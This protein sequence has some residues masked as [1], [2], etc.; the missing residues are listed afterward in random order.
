MSN[1]SYN[2][3]LH[4]DTGKLHYRQLNLYLCYIKPLMNVYLTEFLDPENIKNTPVWER[5]ATYIIWEDWEAKRDELQTEAME[6]IR[7][8]CPP[9]KGDMMSRVLQSQ[10]SIARHYWGID[11]NS[12]H[13]TY[14]YWL[15]ILVE[16]NYRK[17]LTAAIKSLIS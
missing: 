3:H 4:Y 16:D 2:N 9:E 13:Y 5:D 10:M 15:D 12:K 8:I 11:F 7:E 17:K 6:E 1:N 14:M